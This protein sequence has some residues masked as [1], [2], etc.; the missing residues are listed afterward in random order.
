MAIAEDNFRK[1]LKLIASQA[2]D[3]QLQEIADTLNR[4][5]RVHRVQR[6]AEVAAQLTLGSP[7]RI[8]YSVKPNYLRGLTG[9]ITDFRTTKVTVKLDNGPVGK[10]WDGTVICPPSAL[11]VLTITNP[12]D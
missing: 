7:V 5:Y 6:S 3:N 4:A 11:E 1:L 9:T 8:R 10:F 2:D 12:E